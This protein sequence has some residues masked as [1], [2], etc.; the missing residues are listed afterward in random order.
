MEALTPMLE[1]NTI[2]TQLETEK[3]RTVKIFL[4]KYKCILIL[5]F[6][7]LALAQMIYIMIDKLAS[8]EQFMT[9]FFK[10]LNSRA[11]DDP[12]NNNN[13]I[14]HTQQD[15]DTYVAAAAAA[16]AAAIGTGG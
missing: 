15:N 11:G 5:T 16:A 13:N 8:D 7:L 2:N 10:L 12:H 14:T 4:V 6:L 9:Q 3:S 1:A